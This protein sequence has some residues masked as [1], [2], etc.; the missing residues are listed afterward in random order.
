[1]RFHTKNMMLRGKFI[2]PILVS[3]VLTL[4]VGA[5]LLVQTARQTSQEQLTLSKL[6]LKA[7]QQS[8]ADS[9]L[10]AL[11]SKADNLGLF[12]SK[13]APDLVL[14][15]DF[16]ALKSYQ[17]YAAKDRDVA[18]SAYLKPDGTPMIE[19]KAPADKSQIIEKRYQIKSDEDVLGYVLLGM[20][21][22]GMVKNLATSDAGPLPAELHKKLQAHRWDREPTKWSQ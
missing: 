16:S 18:Y 8:A 13:T 10:S 3:T 17:D 14:S 19:Y 11:E 1:M 5:L 15:Y 21:K 22:S 6:A 9:E 2:A 12:M 7:E 20:S 4:L